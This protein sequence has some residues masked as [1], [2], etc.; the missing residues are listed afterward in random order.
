MTPT[1]RSAPP[2]THAPAHDRPRSARP[3]LAGQARLA[4]ILTARDRWLLWMLYEHRVLTTTHIA[5]LA[6]TA[7]RRATRRLLRLHEAG[8]IDRFR[9]RR[10]VGTAPWHWIL[11]PAGAAVLAAE[12][13][14]DM[15]ELRWRHDRALGLAHSLHLDHDIGVADW[16]TTL[17]THPE[18][19]LTAWWSQTRCARLWGDLSRP[20]GYGRLDPIPGTNARR[21]AGA[22]EFFLEYDCGTESLTQLSRKLDGYANLAAA[23]G[24]TTPLLIWLPT[25]AREVTARA[26]LAATAAGLEHPDTVPIATA[27]ADHTPATGPAET[28]W[29]PLHPPPARP[30]H[31]ITLTHLTTAWPHLSLT[32]APASEAESGTAVDRRVALPPPPPRPPQ[33]GRL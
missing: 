19:V 16:F 2:T 18:P 27:A 22:L 15:R 5:A 10:P 17:A 14:L 21:D 7:P 24:I 25:G 32:P 11:A 1:P 33:H 20:D 26:T 6:F 23:T 29:L 3:V 12:H 8:V 30:G 28:V 31:R 9:P 13:G 4:G